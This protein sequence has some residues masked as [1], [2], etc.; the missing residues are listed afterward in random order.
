MYGLNDPPFTQ[1]ASEAIAQ[2]SAKIEVR[3]ESDIK[4]I[5]AL[6]NLQYRFG[7]HFV[8]AF[9]SFVGV[10]PLDRL[11]FSAFHKNLVATFTTLHLARR[12]LHGSAAPMLRHS[13]ESLILA[14]FC[15]TRR[16]EDL[17][18]R[19]LNGEMIYLGKAVLRKIQ[20]PDPAPFWEVWGMLS[21]QVHATVYSQQV[22]FDVDQEPRNVLVT[23]GLMQMLLECNYHLLS[24]HLFTSSLEYYAKLYCQPY[25]VPEL[26]RQ[27]RELHNLCRLRLGDPAR[28]FISAY[29]SRWQIAP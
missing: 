17:A 15:S 20:R 7:S 5:E 18:S 8:W 10:S 28:R 21:D 4:R 11:R 2:N 23:F 26:R 12:G 25:E 14:K 29:K 22:G 19:W 24:S 27:A 16:D 1:I 9:D 13:F 3:A 6:L